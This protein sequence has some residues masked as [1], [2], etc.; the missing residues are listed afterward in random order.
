MR[1]SFFPPAPTL[2]PP[3][4]RPLGK[5]LNQTNLNQTKATHGRAR[6]NPPIRLPKSLSPAIFG[7]RWIPH[8]GIYRPSNGWRCCRDR[9]PPSVYLYRA[10][11]F[12]DAQRGYLALPDWEAHR[13]G[14]ARVPL[15]PFAEP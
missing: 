3:L 10:G 15:P 9:T 2:F 5:G 13:L 8:A 4:V 14:L 7:S 12:R 6:P 11:A 1:R